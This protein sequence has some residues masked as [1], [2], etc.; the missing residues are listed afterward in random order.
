MGGIQ[1][2]HVRTHSAFHHT[3]VDPGLHT[4]DTAI[5]KKGEVSI[6]GLPSRCPKR[7]AH[8]NHNP[9]CECCDGASRTVEAQEG[10]LPEGSEGCVGVCQGRTGLWEELG[11]IRD[12]EGTLG[13]EAGPMRETGVEGKGV[14]QGGI[15]GH[16]W[17]SSW[18]L[19]QPL[20]VYEE[21][22]DDNHVIWADLPTVVWGWGARAR[23]LRGGRRSLQTVKGGD[24]GRVSRGGKPSLPQ[25]FLG[26][27]PELDKQNSQG[28]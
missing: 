23:R 3:Q 17:D 15:Q 5:T 21:D 8:S 27:G 12:N 19:G 9:R 13:R 16:L 14:E 20:K 6:L 18:G 2:W 10:A 25:G 11:K 24:R 1:R 22:L 7:L 26:Q 28:I 4:K